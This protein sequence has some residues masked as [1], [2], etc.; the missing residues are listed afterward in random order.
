MKEDWLPVVGYEGVYEVSNLGNIVRV[1]SCTGK[2]CRKNLKKA[3]RRGYRGFT[4]SLNGLTKHVH[5]HRETWRAFRGPIPD[6][7]QLNHKDGNKDNPNL[8]NLEVVTPSENILHSFRELGRELPV[9]PHVPG[10]QNGRAKI[11][12]SDVLEIRSLIDA[13]HS[14]TEVA[15]KFNVHQ[16]QVSRIYLRQSWR[17]M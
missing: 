8:I 7:F 16:T 3:I 14:Q 15:K 10:E 17:H 9:A 4:L 13:G 11:T 6:G 12:E 2:P 1:S 5:A